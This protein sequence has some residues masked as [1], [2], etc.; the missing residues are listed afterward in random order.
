MRYSLLLFLGLA[1]ALWS[2]CGSGERPAFDD[3]GRK[4]LNVWIHSGQPAERRAM[5]TLIEKFHASQ[6]GIR[7]D[8]TVIPEG[9]YTAQVQSAA[10]SGDLPD[11]LEFDGPFL[12]AYAWQGHLQPLDD[13]LPD[14]LRADLLPSILAQGTWNDRLYAVGTF[15]SGLGLYAR[16]SALEAVDARLPEGPEEAWTVQEF[17]E[18]LAALVAA[19]GGGPVLDLKINYRGEWFTYAFSPLLVSAGADLIAR[20]ALDR[21]TGMLDSAAAIEAMETVQRWFTEGRVHPNFDDAAFLNGEVA[22]SWSGHWDYPRYAEAHGDDLLLL[23][24][25]DFGA[26]SRTGQGSWAW[27]ITTRARHP[28]AAMTFLEFLLEPDNIL[29]MTKSN[30]AIPARRAAIA[31]DPGFAPD[32]R[33]HLFVR[34]LETSA[35]PRPR[36]PAYPVITSVFQDAFQRLRDGGEVE[37]I[38]RSAAR[39]IDEDLADHGGYR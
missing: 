5:E 25:P 20:P 17:E 12:Y 31:R 4:L 36:T 28:E 8:L 6:N 39:Q 18:I 3:E 24:L 22:L 10:F 29:T 1:L 16:R 15:D 38:L 33:R 34:Q 23:P 13:L 30:G 19:Q 37:A 11:L 9:A 27:G 35:V 26:G 2:G 7:I 14:D 21:A 32:Q